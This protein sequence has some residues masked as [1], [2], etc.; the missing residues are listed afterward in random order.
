MRT[1]R[2][3]VL[4]PLLC[5]VA[6]ACACTVCDSATGQQV[7][8]GILDG[9]FMHTLMLTALPFPILAIACVLIYL[10]MP[11]MQELSANPQSAA[12]AQNL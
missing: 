8:A 7:R 3:C 9:R 5:I 6:D 1:Y 2:Y 4:A 11:D 10:A 12:P